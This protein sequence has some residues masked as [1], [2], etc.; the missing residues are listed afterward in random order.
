M[1]EADSG[2]LRDHPSVAATAVETLVATALAL[3]V[4]LRSGSTLVWLFLPLAILVARRRSLSDHG[5]DLRLRPPSFACHLL[6]GGAH[7]LLDGIVHATFA[8]ATGL[9]PQAPRLSWHLAEDLAEEL[10]VVAVPEEVFFRGYLQTRWNHAL[11]T[12]WRL[13]GAQIGPG[14]LVQGAIFAAC[15]LATGDWTRLRVFFFA[16]LAGWL[17]DRSGSIL[18]P[19][20]YHAV[21]NVW[22]RLLL[23]AFR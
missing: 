7:L 4:S 12:P 9:H 23:S 5:L 21:A 17:R 14:I 8:V 18:G 13:A 19:A 3:Y 22:F 10:L 20:V 2:T 6:F 11:G 15:H 16:L 1:G